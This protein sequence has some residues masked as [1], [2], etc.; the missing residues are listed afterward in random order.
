ML[1]RKS[2]GVLFIS[3]LMLSSL[4]AADQSDAFVAREEGL[5]ATN[6]D[7]TLAATPI[8]FESRLTSRVPLSDSWSQP[9]VWTLLILAHEIEGYV[10]TAV[11]TGTGKSGFRGVALQ[12]TIATRE[13]YFGAPIVL[14]SNPVPTSF[15]AEPAT[16]NF[17]ITGILF[18]GEVARRQVR[19][20]YTSAI[21]TAPVV[22]Q[23]VVK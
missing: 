21:C 8:G 11:V 22:A 10:L 13:G 17:L 18:V 16:A 14:S 7:L 20:G 6:F 9:G 4:A 2:A 3:L 19:A 5:T 15:V 23:T 12:S 1:S